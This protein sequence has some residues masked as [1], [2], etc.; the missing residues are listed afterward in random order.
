MKVAFVTVIREPWGGSEEL[1]AASA[2]L[3]LQK[4]HQVIISAFNTERVDQ[5]MAHLIQ[6][7]AKLFYRRGYVRPG[8]AVRQ[9]IKK[10]AGII[11]LNQLSNPYKP[12]FDEKP[13]VI[14][15]N[16]VCD[17]LKDDPFFLKMVEKTG[18]PFISILHA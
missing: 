2:N 7:G 17:S 11:L 10:K 16:G 12:F 3:L 9:R 18:I 15:Y 8:I 6:K 1:W 13:D 5:K 4:G 14:V